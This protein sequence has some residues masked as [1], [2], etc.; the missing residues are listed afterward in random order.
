MPILLG[1]ALLGA[2]AHWLRERSV[3][4]A[5]VLLPLML[6]GMILLHAHFVFSP[7]YWAYRYDAYLVGFGVFVAAVVLLELEPK[8]RLPRGA[9]AALLS[10]GLVPF[11]ADVPEGLLPQ[12]EIEGIRGTYLEQFQTARFIRT[13]YPDAAVIVNDLGAVTYYTDARILD[14]VGLGDIEP[15]RIMR[16]RAYTSADVVAWTAA[17]HP[18]LAVVSLDWAVAAP[19]VPRE[20]VSVAVV[21]MPPHRHRVGF[22]AV[23]PGEAWPLRA[24]VEQ[25]YEP[26]AARMG[27]RVKLR[28]PEGL[29]AQA[30]AGALRSP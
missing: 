26:L 24:A 16:K 18:R 30:A 14:L 13:Y 17:Y 23:A 4:R 20:W 22:F 9:L 29:D 25:F 5:P 6:A 28:Q 8:T 2:V 21:E 11:V 1:L 3:F 12:A 15:V 19:L 7:L 27:H 10:A